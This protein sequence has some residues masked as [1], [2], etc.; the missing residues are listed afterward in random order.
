MKVLMTS[1]TYFSSVV[2][3]WFFLGYQPSSEVYDRSAI[4]KIKC[5]H[6]AFSCLGIYLVIFFFFLYFFVL[7]NNLVSEDSTILLCCTIFTTLSLPWL[8]ILCPF[9]HLYKYEESLP[10]NGKRL[11]ENFWR[12]FWLYSK[13]FWV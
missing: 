10:L 5:T 2:C 7:F 3:F 6:S 13:L 1:L 9:S 8:H 12:K 4:S 11:N